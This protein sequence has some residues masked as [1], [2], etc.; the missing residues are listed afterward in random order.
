MKAH[1]MLT[2]T[3]I[4]TTLFPVWGFVTQGMYTAAGINLALGFLWLVL[5]WKTIY[6]AT[7]VLF[8]IVCM[9]NALL[10]F[11]QISP[12][13]AL[14]SV[15]CGLASWDLHAFARR[16]SAL[17]DPDLIA[18]F[19][20][21]HLMRLGLT[22]FGGLV[23]GAAGLTIH[24]RLGFFVA[25]LLGIAALLAFWYL[26]VQI[27]PAPQRPPRTTSFPRENQEEE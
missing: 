11:F 14:L 18:R 17:K 4:L 27:A 21:H 7:P 2:A 22:L 25:F 1:H 6:W 8:L 10:P 20:R 13:L 19:E 3:I 26:I 23:L 24:F 12:F 15:V 16:M 9:E 5:K